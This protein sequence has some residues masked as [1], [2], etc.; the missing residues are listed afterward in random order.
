M[1][2]IENLVHNPAYISE[3]LN[4]R[5]GLQGAYLQA[6]PQYQHPSC[7]TGNPHALGTSSQDLR[8]EI[9]GHS[10]RSVLT[11]NGQKL[12][13]PKQR[14]RMSATRSMSDERL[15]PGP[16]KKQPRS[17]RKR[18]KSSNSPSATSTTFYS[19][20]G[21]I[22]EKFKDGKKQYLIDWEDDPITGESYENTWV[23]HFPQDRT[24]CGIVAYNARN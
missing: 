10:G 12:A 9:P 1:Q 13:E 18:T 5:H 22:S 8:R 19:V 14:R 16:P 21:I 23:G 3:L 11:K 7:D 15:Q 20:R 24:A 6:Q 2:Q 4:S 17:S